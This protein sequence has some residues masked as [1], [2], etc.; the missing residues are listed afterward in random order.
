MLVLTSQE[1]DKE[2][3]DFSWMEWDFDELDNP[4]GGRITESDLSS[5]FDDDDQEVS[6]QERPDS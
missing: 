5:L 4:S 1:F 2:I 6:A 3:P